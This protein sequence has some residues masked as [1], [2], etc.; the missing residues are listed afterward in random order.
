MGNEVYANG[1]EISCKAAEGKSVCAFPD[2]CLSPPSPPAGPVPIPYPNTGFATDTTSGSKTVQISGKEIMLK[3]KSFFKKSTGDEAATKSLGM[4]VVTHQITGK[5]YFT[6][7]SMD[8]KAEGE[9]VVRHLDLTTHNHASVPGNTPTWPYLD[10]MAI[11]ADHPCVGDMQKEADACKEFKPHGDK[12]AC[13]GIAQPKDEQLAERVSDKVA[14]DKCLAARRCQLVPYSPTGK[15]ARCCETPDKKRVQSPHHLVETGSF[16]NVG[17]GGEGSTPVMGTEGYDEGLAPCVC[18]EG[19]NQY[20]GTHGLMHALQNTASLT[21]ARAS[22]LRM[23]D[24]TTMN[25]R[26]TTYATARQQGIDAMGAVFPESACNPA[27]LESQLNKYHRQHGIKD[28]TPIRAIEEGYAGPGI[29]ED[30]AGLVAAR[31][32]RVRLGPGGY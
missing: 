5:V 11:G 18:A 17:R 7:W 26:I 4:G 32:R 6:S 12:D 23:A 1:R 13:A 19:M 29:P 22:T 8:V 25:T 27:C 20:H 30:V 15:M 9:N 31:S 10:G 28:R 3:D 16:F 2:V 24:N 21:S 14:S